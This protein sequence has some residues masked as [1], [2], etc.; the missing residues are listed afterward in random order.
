MTAAGTTFKPARLT[1][2]RACSFMRATSLGL[3]AANVGPCDVT[4]STVQLRM[5][6]PGQV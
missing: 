2:S 3:F 6:T 4:E 5:R 1:D